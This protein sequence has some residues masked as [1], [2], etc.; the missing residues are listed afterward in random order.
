MKIYWDFVE[1]STSNNSV[2]CLETP[3]EG[4]QQPSLE[5]NFFEGSTTSNESYVDNNFTTNA[6]QLIFPYKLSDISYLLNIAALEEF[7]KVIR[8]RL[9]I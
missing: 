8:K 3:E 2:N 5:S 6:E 7:D 1:Q 4:N 9:M